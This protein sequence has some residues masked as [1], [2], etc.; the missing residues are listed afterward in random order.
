MSNDI[1]LKFSNKEYVKEFLKKMNI[2]LFIPQNVIEKVVEN[3]I[4]ER[5]NW[6]YFKYPIDPTWILSCDPNCYHVFFTKRI[7]KRDN[8]YYLLYI[9]NYC[10]ISEFND[11]VKYEVKDG[12]Y[13]IKYSERNFDVVIE[14]SYP[15]IT[16]D[17]YDGLEMEVINKTYYYNKELIQNKSY[18]VIN[19]DYIE[20]IDDMFLTILKNIKSKNR[21]DE[22]KNMIVV[23]YKT[24]SNKEALDIFMK[25]GIV[26]ININ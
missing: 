12:F 5:K 22:V 14:M 8:C 4:N 21:D 24:V 16:V 13:N 2:N 19:I 10:F 23:L 6:L 3:E 18:M 15:K 7:H 1:I 20:T 17:S 9:F 26:C 11:N 25:E